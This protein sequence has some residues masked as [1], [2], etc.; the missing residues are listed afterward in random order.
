ML[1]AGKGIFSISEI[2]LDDQI[3]HSF[4]FIWRTLIRFI[5][6]AVVGAGVVLIL[7]INATRLRGSILV[8]GLH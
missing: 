3:P 6:N 4:I 2:R 5:T 8:H 1:V 7:R